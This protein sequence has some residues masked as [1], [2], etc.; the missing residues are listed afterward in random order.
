ML[1]VVER[2]VNVIRDHQCNGPTNHLAAALGH[3]HLEFN[4]E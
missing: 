4:F 3:S 2:A 1:D